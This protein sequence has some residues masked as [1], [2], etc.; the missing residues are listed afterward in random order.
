MCCPKCIE[1]INCPEVREYGESNSDC[2]ED[3]DVY[4]C[5]NHP[6]HIGEESFQKVMQATKQGGKRSGR[7]RYSGGDNIAL[8]EI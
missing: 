5:R 8:S 7:I 1:Y 2:C 3:C 6:K 4:S